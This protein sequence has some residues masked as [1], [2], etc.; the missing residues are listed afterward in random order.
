MTQ[1]PA[2]APPPHHADATSRKDPE[3]RIDLSARLREPFVHVEIGC[4]TTKKPGAIGLDVL[5]LPGVDVVCDLNGLGFLPDASVD[6]IDAVHVFEHLSNLEQV[7]REVTRVLKPAGECHI[8]VPYFANPHYYSDYT[9]QTTWG[10]YSLGYFCEAGWPYRRRVPTFYSDV[11]V[12]VL[13]QKLV[14]SSMFWPLKVLKKAAQALVN[15][16][17]R[18]QELYEE[19]LCWL[20]PASELKIVFGRA[21]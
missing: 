19:N 10:L 2:Q 8:R 20:L 13:R 3:I 4:G 7:L 5:P 9:H 17:P 14:F 18:V 1:S 11:R 12:R 15:A 16:H 6:R 21:R